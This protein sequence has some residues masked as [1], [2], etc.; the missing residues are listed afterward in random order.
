MR[1]LR[2][3]VALALLALLAP[4]ARAQMSPEAARAD[5]DVLQRAIVE[6][7]GAPYRF[8][9]KAELDRRFDAARASLRE[10]VTSRAFAALAARTLAALRDGHSSIELDSATAAASAAARRFPLRVTLEGERIVVLFNDTPNDSTIR[11]GMEV[12]RI[13][14]VPAADVLARILPAVPGDGFIETGR[15]DR[16]GRR[17]AQYYWLHVDST[18]RFIVEARD[19]DRRVAATLDGVTDAERA[20]NDNPVNRAVRAAIARVI[21]G[22]R[23]SV[24]LRFADDS[25]VAVLRV[26]AFG[27]ATFVAALDSA[28]DALRV[29]GTSGLVLDLRGN[30]GGTDM[31][32]ASL[33]SH[34]VRA[35]FR[36]FD[37]IHLA[38]INPSFATWTPK[39]F[40]DLRA[41]TTADPAGGSSC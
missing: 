32:G 2:S 1:L 25:T 16:L 18:E 6:A 7:H 30:G 33:V 14:G 22:G 27:G 8:T 20:R 24:S 39:T 35:P 36:Y 13:N 23:E 15:R 41:G 5:L 31:Y 11:P 4:A 9:S 29:R 26:R 17:F 21:G 12:V 10:P 28:F 3:V 37:H 38:T 40:D 34:L 19:G